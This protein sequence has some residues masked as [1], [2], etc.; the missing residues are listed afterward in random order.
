MWVAC[1]CQSLLKAHEL[2]VSSVHVPSTCVVNTFLKSRA[3]RKWSHDKKSLL[4]QL[5]LITNVLRGRVLSTE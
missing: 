2:E 3:R 4:L 5:R 1:E